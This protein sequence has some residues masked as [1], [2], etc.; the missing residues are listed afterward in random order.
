M[1]R[2]T[3]E[4]RVAFEANMK[5]IQDQIAAALARGYTAQEI[6]PRMF[7]LTVIP[8]PPKW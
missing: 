7:D 3:C 5:F 6:I 1:R 8:N 2:T 4:D